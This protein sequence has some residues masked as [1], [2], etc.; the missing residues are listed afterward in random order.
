M[1]SINFDQENSITQFENT[2]MFAVITTT[3]IR[4]IR[5]VC[6]GMKR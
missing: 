4:S 3:F 6:G 1:Y 2:V 5:Q